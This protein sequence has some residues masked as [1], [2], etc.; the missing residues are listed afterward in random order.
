MKERRPCGGWVPDRRFGRGDAASR[1]RLEFV[2][3]GGGRRRWRKTYS[4]D[5]QAEVWAL[6]AETVFVYD[7]WNLIRETTTDHTQT[8]AVASSRSYVWGLDL[9][10]TLQGAGGVGGLPS[11][12]T[13]DASSFVAYDGNGNV[14]AL[15]HAATGAVA[16]EYDYS[17]FGE[18]V[19]AAGLAAEGNPFRFST[20]Y[21]EGSPAGP[22]LY[23]YGHRYYSPP[24][25]RWVNRDPI[26]ERGG[27][28]QVPDS[29]SR[30]PGAERRLPG[31]ALFGAGPD[32][33]FVGNGPAARIDVLGLCTQ[34]AGDR[35]PGVGST[36]CPSCEVKDL[37]HELNTASRIL[38]NYQAGLPPNQGFPPGVLVRVAYTRCDPINPLN[39][40]AGLP[41]TGYPASG[42]GACRGSCIVAHEE[43]HRQQCIHDYLNFNWAGG[44]A[45]T[46]DQEQAMEIPAYQAE[47]GCLRTMLSAANAEANV[48]GSMLKACICCRRRQLAN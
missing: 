28:A 42:M 29:R 35:P 38:A 48:A 26:G 43:V 22:E 19:K 8:P 47:I 30:S 31:G 34:C 18:T 33:V 9:S 7:G 39:P 15:V 13:G 25:G 3:D 20:K 46:Y 16:A 2:Y 44:Y 10:Q 21:A 41:H 5:A 1:P 12:A 37:S 24:I 32:F 40:A 27:A 45:A 6:A 23:Y 4:W 14:V 17:P 36:C 11:V